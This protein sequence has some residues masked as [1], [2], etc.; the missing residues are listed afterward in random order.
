MQ[1]S[2]A[3]AP[4]GAPPGIGGSV[5]D[6]SQPFELVLDSKFLFFESDDPDFIPVGIGHLVLDNVL[7][8]LV[9]VGQMIDMSL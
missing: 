3:A 4:A 7:D 5:N 1:N 9:L 6:V 2:C 8:F